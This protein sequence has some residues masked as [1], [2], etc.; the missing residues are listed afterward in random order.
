M[1]RDTAGQNDTRWD[2]REYTVDSSGQAPTVT[3]QPS[4]SRSPRR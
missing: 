2:T 3:D 1:A 4:R